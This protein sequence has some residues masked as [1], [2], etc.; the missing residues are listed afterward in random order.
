MGKGARFSA[1][2]LVA[3]ALITGIVSCGR[4]DDEES[5]TKAQFVKRATLICNEGERER[6]EVLTA[7]TQKFEEGEAQV[8]PQLQEQVILKIL[9]KYEAMTEKLADLSP[10]E[11]DEK[12]VEAIVTAM[13]EG[14]EKVKAN[15]Q[16]A[17]GTSSAFKQASEKLA[18]YGLK[19]CVV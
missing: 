13:E 18:D 5:L 1:L 15:P 17:V 4:G 14:T 9:T 8:T 7:E 16:S 10:P 6:E 19:T 2:A 3:V 12:Q 11:G